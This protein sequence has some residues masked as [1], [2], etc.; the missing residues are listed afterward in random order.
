MNEL[1]R[2]VG[3]PPSLKTPPP[4]PARTFPARMALQLLITHLSIVGLLPLRQYM[5]PPRESLLITGAYPF[6]SVIPARTEF[7][8]SPD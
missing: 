3:L 8:R 5:P 1:L 4:N 6:L 7:A 2:I